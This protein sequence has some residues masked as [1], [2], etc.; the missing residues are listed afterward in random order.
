M[1]FHYIIDL[2]TYQILHSNYS[3][4]QAISEY[5]NFISSIAVAFRQLKNNVIP[6]I[7]FSLI[8]FHFQLPQS[9]LSLSIK[10][11]QQPIAYNRIINRPPDDDP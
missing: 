1:D 2:I 3:Y 10:T 6:S 9:P 5:I 11:I 4:F 8:I 7:G